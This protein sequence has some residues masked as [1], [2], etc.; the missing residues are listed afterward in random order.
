MAQTTKSGARQLAVVTGASSGIGFELARL[1]AQNNYDLIIAADDA[2]IE[3]AAAELRSLGA[4]VESVQVDL[5]TPDG[6]ERLAARP[7]RSR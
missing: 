6:V 7:M 1:F 5:A 2:S 3:T 4:L